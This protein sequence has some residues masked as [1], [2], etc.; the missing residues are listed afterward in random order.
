MKIAAMSNAY[1]FLIILI[2]ILHGI[3]TPA[4]HFEMATTALANGRVLGRLR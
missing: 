4:Y 2:I 1:D 3:G